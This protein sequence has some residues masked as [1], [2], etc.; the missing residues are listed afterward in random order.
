M[1]NWTKCYIYCQNQSTTKDKNRLLLA[2]VTTWDQI[3]ETQ[4]IVWIKWNQCCR[5]L[6]HLDIPELVWKFELDDVTMIPISTISRLSKAPNPVQFL[7]LRIGNH[8]RVLIFIFTFIF[9]FFVVIHT[10]IN[11]ILLL[12]TPCLFVPPSVAF[13]S[14]QT[15][16]PQYL[17]IQSWTLV[18]NIPYRITSIM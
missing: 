13:L 10:Y 1:N 17:L 14:P 4:L 11:W 15:S 6:W 16:S 2:I 12:E 5:F 3:L 9:F 18:E 7:S 8:L